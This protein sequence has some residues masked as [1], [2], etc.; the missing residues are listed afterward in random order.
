MGPKVLLA[1]ALLALLS[2]GGPKA[3]AFYTVTVVTTT[4]TTSTPVTLTTTI[5]STLTTTTTSTSIHSTTTQKTTVTLTSTSTLVLTTTS[6]S[7]FTVT[8]TF[9]VSS[10]VGGNPPPGGCGLGGYPPCSSGTN[11]STT[12]KLSPAGPTPLEYGTLAA[13]T[14]T[15]VAL[16]LVV[17]RGG[18][19]Y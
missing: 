11:V 7:T 12:L 18:R 9:T 14:V 13:I 3:S 6:N 10:L 19:K 4:Y 8:S 15:V 2:V 1:V 17:S 16:V 5:L